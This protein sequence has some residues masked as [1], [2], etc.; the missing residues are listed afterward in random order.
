MNNKLFNRILTRIL[1]GIIFIFIGLDSAITYL[2]HNSF[3]VFIALLAVIAG[4]GFLLD[5]IFLKKRE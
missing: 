2:D 1:P 4:I 3:K 5:G